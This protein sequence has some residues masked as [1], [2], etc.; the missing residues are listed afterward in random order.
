MT[1]TPVHNFIFKNNKDL[2][3]AD[4]SMEWGFGK[5]GFLNGAA[6]SDLDNDGDLDLVVSN[7][8]ETASIY[9]NILS[10]SKLPSSNYIRIQ[11]KGADKNTSGLGSKVYVY[12][13]NGV[14]YTEQ[15]PSRGYQSCVSKNLHFGLAD[16]KVVDSIK[17]EWPRGRVTILK[18]IKANQII[19]IAEKGEMQKTPVVISPKMIF[20]PVDSP[21]K[22]EHT[23]YGSNDFQRQPLL[24]SMLSIRGPVMAA[25]DVNGDKLTDVFVGGTKENPGKLYLQSANGTFTAS[26]EF[27][28][29]DDFN[30]TDADATFFD[31]DDDGDQDLYVVSGGYHDYFRND[32]ALTGPVISEQRFRQ[33]L[34]EHQALFR[35]CSVQNHA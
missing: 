17:V 6:Y 31:A 4:K 19:V 1:S 13:S 25:G 8:N 27:N 20:S 32:K 12:T 11:L 29:K 23:E 9:R 2:T 33:D 7:Q 21:I 22:Y 15:M 34:Q 14:Q 3:F 26:K 35:K 30:C 5:K 16:S 18:D 10:E 24:I 28:F